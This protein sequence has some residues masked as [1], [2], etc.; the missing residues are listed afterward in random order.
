MDAVALVAELVE[1]E[2]ATEADAADDG[3]QA[4]KRDG[5][6]RG[7]RDLDYGVIGAAVGVEG[8]GEVREGGDGES[9]NGKEE[10]GDGGMPAG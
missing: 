3:R 9:Q 5:G 8:E 7:E 2:E 10:P 6:G 4:D 1:E